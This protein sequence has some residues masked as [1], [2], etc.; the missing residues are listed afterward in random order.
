MKRFYPLIFAVLFLL[1][2]CDSKNGDYSLHILATNDVHGSW[3]SESYVDNT[4]RRSLVGVKCYVDSIRTGFGAENTLLLDSGDCL[5]GDNAAF[6]F[7]YVD[8]EGTHLFTRLASYMGYD[9]VVVGNHDIEVGPAMYSRMKRELA[10]EGIPFLAGNAFKEDGTTYFPEYKVFRR[11][12]LKVLVLGYTNPNIAAWLDRS[13]WPD[14]EFESLIPLVQQRVDAIKAKEKPDVTIVSVHSGA[15]KGDGEVLESQGLDLYNSLQGVDVLLCSH[16][17]LPLLKQREDC[18]LIDT[19]SRASHLGHAAVTLTFENGKLVAK[20][21]AGE[22]IDI[23]AHKVDVR[24]REHF[25]A[26]FEKVRAFTLRPIGYISE[27]MRTRDAFAGQSFYM[28]IIHKVQLEASGADISFSAPLTFNKTLKAGE[29]IYN[30]LFT[31]YP[32]ENSLNV[33]KLTGKEIRNYLEYSYALWLAD[34]PGYVL[35]IKDDANERYGT[36]HWS[37]VYPSFNFDSAAGIDYTVDL[38]KPYGRRVKITSPFDENA[39]YTVAM[40]SYRAA[41]GGNLLLEGAGLTREESGSRLVARYPEIR[42]MVY[43]FILEHG[44]IT[45]ESVSGIG[46]WRFIPNTSKKSLKRDMS[47]LFD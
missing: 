26:D 5:Q 27:D 18:L 34:E 32:Y 13:L 35:R 22:L 30:D 21:L 40:T 1:N 11:G 10:A 31:L 45:P 23:D 28:N 39:F 2:G 44:T 24:M 6:Y 20:H 38:T 46:T 15:G 29:L 47:L 9:A 25:N 42:E 12:G 17:H 43:R 4:P 8:T 37:F 7:N 41:G 16:D 14:I 3:F 19:G 33:L 36:S